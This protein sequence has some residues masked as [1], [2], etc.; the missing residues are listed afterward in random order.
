MV[1]TR[2]INKTRSTEDYSFLLQTVSEVLSKHKITDNVE[3]EL[4]I[5]GKVYMRRLN[6]D[7]R[8]KNYATDVLSFPIWS[9]LSTIKKQPG[10]ILLGSIIICLPIA[11]RDSQKEG[12]SLHERLNFLV[13]HSLLHLMGFHHDGD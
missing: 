8:R 3:V 11:L 13:K 5:V 2:L 6:L 7:H 1:T 4:Q 9:N 12:V 10:Q